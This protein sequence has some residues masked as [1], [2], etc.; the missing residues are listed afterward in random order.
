MSLRKRFIAS[1]S[2]VSSA[3]PLDAL[4]R[5]TGQ[6]FIMPFYHI[7]SDGDCP[8]IKHLYSSKGIQAFEQDLDYLATHYTPIA[9]SDLPD[10]TA[11]KYH[12]KRIMLL[13]FDDGLR[14]MYDVVAPILLR[15]GIPAIF[16][17]NSAFVDNRALMFRYQVSLLIAQSPSQYAHLLT[18]RSMAALAAQLAGDTATLFSDFLQH[19]QPYM[20]T[21]Q[22]QSLAAKGFAIGGHSIDHPYY[23]DISME[24]QLHQTQSSIDWVSTHCPQAQRLFAFPFTDHGVGRAFFDQVL[25]SGIADYTFGGAGIKRDVHPR[26]IQRMPMEGWTATAEQILKSEYLYYLLRMPIGKNQIKR[27]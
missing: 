4:V 6:S 10:V 20:T 7:V 27:L 19:Y 16:F 12:G 25:D 24:T 2:R 23:E 11:G 21:T 5:A 9:S 26:Q 8:H 22:I 15:K 14:E 13:S 17:V 3:L 18:V 1:S